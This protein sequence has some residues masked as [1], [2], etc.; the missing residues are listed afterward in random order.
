MLRMND[1]TTETQRYRESQFFG[2]LVYR[3][4]L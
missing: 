3:F 2:F 1:F 4:S